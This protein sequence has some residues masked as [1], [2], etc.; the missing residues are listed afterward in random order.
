MGKV[1]RFSIYYLLMTFM[2][3]VMLLIIRYIACVFVRI[4]LE[5][6]NSYRNGRKFR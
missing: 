3:F 6:S 2:F 4:N 1:F 5:K